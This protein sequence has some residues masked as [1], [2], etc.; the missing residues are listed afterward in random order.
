MILEISVY[1]SESDTHSF[2]VPQV[3]SAGTVW[4]HVS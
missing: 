3:I 1:F 2:S 4:M